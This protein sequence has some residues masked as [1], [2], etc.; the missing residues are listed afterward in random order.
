MGGRAN[1]H[2]TQNEVPHIEE[3]SHEQWRHVSP[4]LKATLYCILMLK[5]WLG[6]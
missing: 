3:L 2:A 6:L 5:D 1:N 4:S